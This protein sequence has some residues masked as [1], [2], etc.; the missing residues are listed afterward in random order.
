M[1]KTFLKGGGE[2][3][4]FACGTEECSAASARAV[5]ALEAAT[6][7]AAR[8]VYAVGAGHLQEDPMVDE[9]T[10]AFDW[11]VADDPRFS[12]TP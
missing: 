3:L 4:L 10:R 11:L 2:R 7:G 12:A 6:G 5:S 9:I 1:A 8:M